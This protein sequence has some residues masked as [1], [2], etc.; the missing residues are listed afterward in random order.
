MYIT[1]LYNTSNYT[2]LINS[3]LPMQVEDSIK[4]LTPQGVINVCTALERRLD[5]LLPI[6]HNSYH[7]QKTLIYTINYIIETIFH[8]FDES[9]NSAYFSKQ[10]ILNKVRVLKEKKDK[11]RRELDTIIKYEKYRIK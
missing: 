1:G 9:Y 7:K 6:F 3:P 5:Q 2:E 8:Y 4:V 10:E 11:Y